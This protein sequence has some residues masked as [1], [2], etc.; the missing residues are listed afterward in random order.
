MDTRTATDQIQDAL[1]EADEIPKRITKE[2]HL[3][4]SSYVNGHLPHEAGEAYGLDFELWYCRNEGISH[5]EDFILLRVHRGDK[6]VPGKRRTRRGHTEDQFHLLDAHN[7]EDTRK[8]VWR[9]LFR[10][11][12]KH[13][14]EEP[15]RPVKDARETIREVRRE[16]ERL[17]KRQEEM[18]RYRREERRKAGR[19]FGRAPEQVRSHHIDAV[20]NMGGD[21]AR[22]SPAHR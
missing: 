16:R 21:M 12:H 4:R 7:Y 18:A 22:K 2:R 20:R 8:E 13:V 17:K 14:R 15:E 10:L 5:L 6:L 19:M 11:Y 9:R 3:T 1:R